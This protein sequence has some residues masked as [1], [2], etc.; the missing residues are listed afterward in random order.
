ML[1]ETIPVTSVDI[2]QH[3]VAFKEASPFPYL[4]IDNFLEPFLAECLL[5]DFPPITLMHRSHHYLF[6]NKCELSFW[7][8]TSESFHRLHACLSSH[9]FKSW[10][11][12]ICDEDLFLDPVYYGELHQAQ[13]GGYLDIHTDFNLHPR[14]ETWVHRVTML[15]YLNKDW[16]KNYGGE[17]QLQDRAMQT[18]TEIAPVFNRCVIMRSDNTTYHGY[19]RLN[20]PP[21]ISRKSIL[22]N[23]YT[24][25][26]REAVPPR[27]PSTWA[28]THQ[29]SF[30]S[31]LAY[32]YNPIA[33]LKHKLFGLSPAWSR[34]SPKA[35]KSHRERSLSD[36]RN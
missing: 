24:E 20:L 23:F 30:K 14:Q 26:S 5:D 11:S 25:V 9:D 10:L 34:D 19:Q 13:D 15:I 31:K 36:D 8:N 4:V 27:R 32:F 22:I 16:Q 7:A 21:E 12:K 17:L 2:G 33:E 28:A 29:S 1:H 6:S 35:I 18:S 3:A